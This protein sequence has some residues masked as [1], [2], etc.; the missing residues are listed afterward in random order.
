[1]NQATLLLCSSLVATAWVLVIAWLSGIL[2]FNYNLA[3]LQGR[4]DSADESLNR[5]LA[6]LNEFNYTRKPSVHN[7]PQH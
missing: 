7:Q 2:S 1:M 6:Q 3:N 4:I 5:I